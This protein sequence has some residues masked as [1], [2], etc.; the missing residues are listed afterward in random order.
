MDGVWGRGEGRGDIEGV[1]K[2]KLSCS[3]SLKERE[4][5]KERGNKRKSLQNKLIVIRTINQD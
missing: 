5:E 2:M 3:F 4:K 1:Q